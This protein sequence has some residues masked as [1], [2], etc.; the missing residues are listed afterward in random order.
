MVDGSAIRAGIIIV[1]VNWWEHNPDK[2][3]YSV[4]QDIVGLHDCD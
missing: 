1:C 2:V 4:M 3:L